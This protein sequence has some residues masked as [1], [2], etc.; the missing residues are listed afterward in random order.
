[1]NSLSTK[2]EA[3]TLSPLHYAWLGNES[4]RRESRRKDYMRKEIDQKVRGLFRLFGIG[5]S[6]LES[7]RKEI[8]IFS[9]KHKY[10]RLIEVYLMYQYFLLIYL[11]ALMVI[12]QKVQFPRLSSH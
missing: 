1:M 5:E 7:K 3:V 4:G 8:C 6:T 11:W 12:V 9:N 10:P 2:K